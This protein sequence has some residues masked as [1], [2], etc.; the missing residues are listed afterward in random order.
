MGAWSLRR[1]GPAL[2]IPLLL[3][4]ALSRGSV[5]VVPKAREYLPIVL[6]GKTSPRH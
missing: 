4:A 5:A 1:D 2:Y 3:T 6:R